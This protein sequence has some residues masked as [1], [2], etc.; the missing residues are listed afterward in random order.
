LL[1]QQTNTPLQEIPE[2]AGTGF[3]D[4]QNPTTN[5]FDAYITDTYII[6]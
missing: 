5:L 6:S 2:Y 4:L 1:Q 3:I